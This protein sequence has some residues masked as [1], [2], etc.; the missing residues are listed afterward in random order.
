MPEA[1][2]K[3]MTTS[4][5]PRLTIQMTLS[6]PRGLISR[7]VVRMTQSQCKVRCSKQSDASASPSH[8]WITSPV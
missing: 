5:A 4:N 3:V 1:M 2:H 7:L 6:R 8:S